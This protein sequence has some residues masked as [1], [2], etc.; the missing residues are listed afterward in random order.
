MPINAAPAGGCESAVGSWQSAVG[1]RKTTTRLR[2]TA[3]LESRRP[4]TADRRLSSVGISQSVRD[5]ETMGTF[6]ENA[7]YASVLLSPAPSVGVSGCASTAGRMPAASLAEPRTRYRATRRS[8]RSVAPA[9]TLDQYEIT[10]SGDAIAG[11]D[12]S[13][14]TRPRFSFTVSIARKCRARADAALVSS[15]REEKFRR[16]RE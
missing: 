4:P 15:L 8:K 11:D 3:G 2:L 7:A 1:S 14:P 10:I 5:H 9:P 6:C 12:S 13:E 16:W